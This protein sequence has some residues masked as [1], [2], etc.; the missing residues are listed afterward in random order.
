MRQN[1]DKPANRHTSDS[2]SKFL[3]A[4]DE[5]QND[6][7]WELFATPPCLYSKS[8]IFLSFHIEELHVFAS[9]LSHFGQSIRAAWTADFLFSLP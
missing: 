7:H 1:V 3:P 9:T 2:F 5:N 4:C 8:N 6:A